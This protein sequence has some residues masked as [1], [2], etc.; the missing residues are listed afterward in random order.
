MHRERSE[1]AEECFSRLLEVLLLPV[2]VLLM[3]VEVLLLTVDILALAHRGLLAHGPS[4]PIDPLGPS[5]LPA[6]LCF[7]SCPSMSILIPVDVDA[8]A[9]P[10]SQCCAS[11]SSCL[12]T[13]LLSPVDILLAPRRQTLPLQMGRHTC[14]YRAMCI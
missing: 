12:W 2:E 1:V 7:C 11:T 9:R 13:F 6:H 10:R 3:P 4:L 5:T 14:S 8:H